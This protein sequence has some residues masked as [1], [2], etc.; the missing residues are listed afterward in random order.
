METPIEKK[1]S[2][3]GPKPS[4]EELKKQAHERNIAE[5]QQKEQDLKNRNEKLEELRSSKYVSKTV[6]CDL[7]PVELPKGMFRSPQL[8]V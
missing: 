4:L 3:S 8:M 5:N 7:K 1:P 2:T 6:T